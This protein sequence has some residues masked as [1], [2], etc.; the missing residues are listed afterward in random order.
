MKSIKEAKWTCEI[1]GEGRLWIWCLETEDEICVQKYLYS[2]YYKHKSS[3]ERSLRRFL[4]KNGI[5]NYTIKQ[6]S[7]K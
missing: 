3:C 5:K 2:D 7:N 6:P 1:E 4:E